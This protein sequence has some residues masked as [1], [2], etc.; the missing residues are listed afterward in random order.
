M[1]IIVGSVAAGS[2]QAADGSHGTGA[3][4]LYIV[5]E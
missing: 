5:S 4:S 2:R 3:E 1:T